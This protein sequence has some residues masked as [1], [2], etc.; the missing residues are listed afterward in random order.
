M[1]RKISEKTIKSIRRLQLSPA[2]IIPLL[3]GISIIVF[4]AF[5]VVKSLM[6]FDPT[7]MNILKV[8]L[9]FIVI[10]FTGVMIFGSLAKIHEGLNVKDYLGLFRGKVIRKEVLNPEKKPMYRAVIYPDEAYMY[11][12]GSESFVRADLN[13]GNTH[14]Y[15]VYFREDAFEMYQE[16][17]R[18]ECLI[19]TLSSTIYNVKKIE[20]N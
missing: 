16:G 7:L 3:I 5:S 19:G 9:Y 6:S 14:E 2:K 15:F 8:V 11:D 13:E 4:L 20:D 17:D 10:L 12:K 18:V 1:D